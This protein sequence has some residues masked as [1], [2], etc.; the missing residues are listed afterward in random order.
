MVVCV[1]ESY[2]YDLCDGQTSEAGQVGAVRLP[3]EHQVVCLG[4]CQRRVLDRGAAHDHCGAEQ[5]L[6]QGRLQQSPHR[7]AP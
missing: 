5:T 7:G 3:Q 2:L 4:L 6:S 1:C